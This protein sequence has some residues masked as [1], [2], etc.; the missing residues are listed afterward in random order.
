MT[1]QRQMTYKEFKSLALNPPR[2]DEETIFQVIGY[3]VNQNLG[4]RKSLYPEFDL[5]HRTVGFCHSVAEAEKLIADAIADDRKYQSEPYCFY[6]KEYPIG[7]YLGTIWEGYGVS[8][9]LYDSEGRFLDKTYCSAMDRDHRTP[10][11]IFRGRPAESIRFKEGDVVEVRDGDSVHLAVVASSP[12]T[13]ERGWEM[14][15]NWKQKYNGTAP[16]S[17]SVLVDDGKEDGFPSDA[18]DDQSPVIDGPSYDTHDHILTL[19]IMPL[20]YPLSDKLRKKYEGYYQSMLKEEEEYLRQ[21][22]QEKAEL[23]DHTDKILSISREYD[24]KSHTISPREALSLLAD[25]YIAYCGISI[26]LRTIAYDAADY[27]IK[28]LAMSED[29]LAEKAKSASV[30]MD[31]ISDVS[32]EF[33]ANK[34][35]YAEYDIAPLCQ[36]EAV[37]AIA[38]LLD[39]TT[40]DKL[41]I[42]LSAGFLEVFKYYH[43]YP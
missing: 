19:N 36:S 4:R 32:E 31:I 42:A 22:E 18:G 5:R 43:Q 25:C 6:V 12:M 39:T 15:D 13:I 28:K 20:R 29:C 14:R 40:D 30:F 16:D 3:T 7:K 34:D 23:K 21:C 1:R 24:K 27:W 8:M 10:Y 9:R 35:H 11:G 41:K 26:S 2:R 17:S 38:E 33:A 37:D